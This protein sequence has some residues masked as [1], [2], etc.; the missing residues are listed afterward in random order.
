MQ[1]PR[2][3]V[4][5]F[6][7]KEQQQPAVRFCPIDPAD[8]NLPHTEIDVDEYFREEGEISAVADI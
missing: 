6:V 8:P 4:V 7:E 3:N 1:E 5:P 2:T